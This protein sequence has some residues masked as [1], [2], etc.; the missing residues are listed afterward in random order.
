MWMHSDFVL[1]FGA[2]ASVYFGRSCRNN[3]RYCVV[4]SRRSAKFSSGCEWTADGF[5]Q[6]LGAAAG[7]SEQQQQPFPQPQ[8]VPYRCIV[9]LYCPTASFCFPFHITPSIHESITLSLSLSLSPSLSPRCI[10]FFIDVVRWRELW[11]HWVVLV[12]LWSSFV[13]FLNLYIENN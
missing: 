2:L 13:P 5:S 7:N 12:K 6:S 9:S 11:G 10:V 1:S 4:G 3:V 8:S